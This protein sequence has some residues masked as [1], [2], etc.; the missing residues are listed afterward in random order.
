MERRAFLTW[1]GVG[2]VASSLPIALAACDS[3]TTQTSLASQPQSAS[4]GGYKPVGSVSELDKNG[5]LLS[6]RSPVG[7]VLLVRASAK[8][9][10]AVNPTCTHRG[11]TV[12]W[13][14]QQNKFY[15]PCHSA[16]YAPD[17]KVIKGPATRPLKT[18]AAKIENDSILVKQS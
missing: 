10:V 6:K 2:W 4:S 9:L 16:E 13:V 15:C 3:K 8:N 5:Y 17:G 18:Y 14:A 7:P 1:V 12:A 11:C